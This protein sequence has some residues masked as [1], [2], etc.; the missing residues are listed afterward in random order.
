MAYQIYNCYTDYWHE[1]GKICAQM[2]KPETYRVI[3]QALLAKM[4]EADI[5][6]FDVDTAKGRHELRQV[7]QELQSGSMEVLDSLPEGQLYWDKETWTMEQPAKFVQNKGKQIMLVVDKHTNKVISNDNTSLV[8]DT[9]P[10]V[11]KAKT[12]PATTP[13]VFKSGKT[14]QLAAEIGLELVDKAPAPAPVVP[15]TTKETKAMTSTAS[16]VKTI[17][18]DTSSSLAANLSDKAIKI[19]EQVKEFGCIISLPILEI[20]GTRYAVLKNQ[21]TVDA[22]AYFST[23][24]PT[25]YLTNPLMAWVKTPEG[26]KLVPVAIQEIQRLAAKSPDETA[27]RK[28]TRT[29]PPVAEPQPEPEIVAESLPEEPQSIEVAAVVVEKPAPAISEELLSQIEAAYHTNLFS[30]K[31]LVNKAHAALG[32]PELDSKTNKLAAQAAAMS[33]L[34]LFG[35]S[36]SANKPKTEPAQ[37]KAKAAKSDDKA[38]AMKAA[39]IRKMAEEKGIDISQY[40][41]KSSKDRA[42]ATDL[43]TSA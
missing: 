32:K 36:P 9:A 21:A 43:V 8:E 1:T 17:L 35:K 40:N 22:I 39:D 13:H 4:S 28:S 27:L 6:A 25:F 42:A 30:L 2:Q 14:Q 33:V 29:A 15:T 24:R 31:P 20:V 12:A 38:S 18:D 11:A 41:M 19:Y 5:L 3:K 23:Q 10:L 34:A 16:A 7:I 37:P 26:M